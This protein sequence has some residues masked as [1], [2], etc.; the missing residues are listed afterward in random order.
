LCWQAKRKY[1]EA[2]QERQNLEADRAELQQKY[3]QKAQ[4]ARKLQEM[5]Q[6]AQR[7]N[8]ALRSGR[9]APAVAADGSLF[10]T[11]TPPLGHGPGDNRGSMVTAACPSLLLGVA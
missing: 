9:H 1:T 4:Q 7:E 11:T 8:E 3:A 2:V 5:L 6:K 10:R